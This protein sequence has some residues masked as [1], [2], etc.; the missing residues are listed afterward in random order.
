MGNYNQ[1]LDQYMNLPRNPIPMD[2][3]FGP[4]AQFFSGSGSFQQFQPPVQQQQQQQQQQQFQPP[5][6]QNRQFKENNPP[7]NENG[8]E[9]FGK[10]GN[11]DQHKSKLNKDLHNEYNEYLQQKNSNNRRNNNNNMQQTSDDYYA[12]L[13]LKGMEA[14]KVNYYLV[15]FLNFIRLFFFILF[16]CICTKS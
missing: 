13:P 4:E 2:N 6:P 10:F 8:Q 11:Y 12:T 3:Q 1:Q 7:R 14:S 16:A 5:P 15:I 9:F